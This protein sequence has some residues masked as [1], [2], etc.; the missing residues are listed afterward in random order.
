MSEAIK[1][2]GAAFPQGERKEERFTDNGGYGQSRTVTIATGGLSVRDYFAAA[3]LTGILAA[4]GDWHSDN[5]LAGYAFYLADAMLS[6]RE[7]GTT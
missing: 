5:E 2:G 7:K 6:A 4:N 1:D 3:A